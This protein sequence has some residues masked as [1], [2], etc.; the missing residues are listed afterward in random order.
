MRYGT[1]SGIAAAVVTHGLD[2]DAA[3]EMVGRELREALDFMR[4]VWPNGA[5]ALA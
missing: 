5:E 1:R 3:S 2:L 4:P